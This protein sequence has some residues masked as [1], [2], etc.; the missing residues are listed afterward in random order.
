[1]SWKG[2]KF[3]PY[4]NSNSDPSAVQP[5]M[6]TAI[7]FRITSTLECVTVLSGRSLPRMR[8]P[9]IL[10][11]LWRVSDPFRS[12]ANGLPDYKVSYSRRQNAYS[13]SCKLGP[14]SRTRGAIHPLPRTP[15]WCGV[16]L[17]KHR[18]SF[19]CLASCEPQNSLWDPDIWYLFHGHSKIGRYTFTV[20]VS[21][22]R[23]EIG[24]TAM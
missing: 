17:V 6:P 2:E 12:L 7:S 22:L 1:M 4:R 24:R 11:P 9:H 21:E 3:C 13:P 15:S 5:G 8:R 19:T 14:W 20:I 10:D 18:D 23:Q 16:Y